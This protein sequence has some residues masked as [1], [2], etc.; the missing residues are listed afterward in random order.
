MTGTL[1][2]DQ[3]TY[4]IIS[5]S[6]LLRMR[7]VLDKNCRENQNTH[8]MFNNFFFFNCVIYEKM[9]KKYHRA[10]QAIDDS[11]AHVLHAGYLRLQTY[12]QNMQYLLPFHC[13]GGFT[14]VSHCCIIHML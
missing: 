1:Q 9:W 14:N 12:T 6:V 13:N 3:C 8:F 2:E 5:R 11:L 7:N 4:M 10:G